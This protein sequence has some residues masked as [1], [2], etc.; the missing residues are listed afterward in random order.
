[1]KYS[2]DI[3]AADISAPECTIKLPKNCF[4]QTREHRGQERI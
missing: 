1:M 4:E 3:D 2:I